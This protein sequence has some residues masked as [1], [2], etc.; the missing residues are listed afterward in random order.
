[1]KSTCPPDLAIVQL[2]YACAACGVR[3]RVVNVP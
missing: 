1:M 3:D 2:Q